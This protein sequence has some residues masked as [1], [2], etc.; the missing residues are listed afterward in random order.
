MTASQGPNTHKGENEVNSNSRDFGHLVIVGKRGEKEISH[1]KRVKTL[2]DLIA[3]RVVQREKVRELMA[4]RAGTFDEK[5]SK[6][7]L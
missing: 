5:T 4:K 7:K 2:T 1:Q 3:M 6:E